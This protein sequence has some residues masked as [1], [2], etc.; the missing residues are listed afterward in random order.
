[1]DAERRKVKRVKVSFTLDPD[2]I[3]LLGVHAALDQVTRS[4]YLEG[5][6]RV[7]LTK[8]DMPVNVT[9]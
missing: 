2:V 6:L 7:S 9:E 3:K 5:L 4:E 1:M 8:W